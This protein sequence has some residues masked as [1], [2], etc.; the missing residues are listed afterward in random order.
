[1]D[2]PFVNPRRQR[3]LAL[4]V[5]VIVLI[6]GS[7][8]FLVK[9]LNSTALRLQRTAVSTNVLAQA[10]DAL[11]GF[12]ATNSNQPGELPCP[13]LNSPYTPG[14]NPP[15]ANPLAGTATSPCTYANQRIGR[16]PWKTLGLPDLRDASGERLW[17]ALSANFLNMPGSTLINSDTAGTLNLNGNP[18]R[19]SPY[20]AMSLA[21]S[22]VA[23]VIA[24]GAAV[25]GQIRNPNI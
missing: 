5:M 18:P 22:I 6:L 16:L 23:I 2:L 9:Q 8:F 20:T 4:L 12:A 11:I 21:N 10:K 17:Y 24:P 3:G 14:S 19:S 13:D 25:G 1:M 7:T 15:V